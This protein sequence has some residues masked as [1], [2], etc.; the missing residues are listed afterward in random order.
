ML[1]VSID[2][3]RPIF[4]RAKPEDIGNIFARAGSVEQAEILRVALTTIQREFPLQA[5]YIA[6][7]LAKPNHDET[8][9][10]LA[11]LIEPIQAEA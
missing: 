6:I 7:E 5:D 11:Y 8:R 9:R 10:L 3:S 1:E 4:V 2:S